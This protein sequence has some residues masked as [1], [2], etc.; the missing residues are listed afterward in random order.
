M[1]SSDL[2]PWRGELPP[3]HEFPARGPDASDGTVRVPAKARAAECTA[4]RRRRRLQRGMQP[5]ETAVGVFDLRSGRLALLR[6][7]VI[8]YAASVPKVAILLSWFATQPDAVA[9]LDATTRHE[10][11][12]MIKLSDNALAAKYSRLIGLAR[13]QEVLNTE[14]FYDAAHGGGLWM[15]KHYGQGDERRLVPFRMPGAKPCMCA[16]SV[17][18]LP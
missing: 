12:L 11:G 15:G 14:G 7:D 2:A 5:A 8:F 9:R 6:P 13:I 18:Y 10:L 17:V 4:E 3:L 1:C 16:Y